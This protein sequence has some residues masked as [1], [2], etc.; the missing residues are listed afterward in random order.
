MSLSSDDGS[1]HSSEWSFAYE[2]ESD[3]EQQFSHSTNAA[4]EHYH[5]LYNQEP[6]YCPICCETVDEGCALLLLCGHSFCLTCFLTYLQTR[7]GEGDA[8]AIGCPHVLETTRICKA[9]VGDDILREIMDP[10]EWNKWRDFRND[11]FV[12]KNVDYHHC[13][14]PDCANIVL[15]K[16]VVDEEGHLDPNN[17]NNSSQQSIRVPRICDCFKCGRTSCLSCGASPFHT[18]QTCQQHKQLQEFQDRE[19]K[20]QY[21]ERVRDRRAFSLFVE[22]MRMTN[23][24]HQPTEQMLQA[25]ATGELGLYRRQN[26]LD[27]TPYEFQPD[28]SEENDD[29]HSLLPQSIKQCRRCGNGIELSDGCLKIKC[30]CGYRFCYQCGSENAQCSCTASG[31][32]FLDPVTGRGDFLGLNQEKSAT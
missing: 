30:I 3:Y 2:D 14:T 10:D 7:V 16:T 31:H 32:G 15:C 1:I 22:P 4:H 5:S 21:E 6:A 24:E 20:R 29:Q 23:D 12:R 19:R 9:I 28:I 17:N 25:R 18:N 27:D 11:A 13:P 26:P 8:D